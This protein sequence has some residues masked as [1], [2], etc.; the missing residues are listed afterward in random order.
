MAATADA[1][2]PKWFRHLQSMKES[3]AQAMAT[4]TN[5]QAKGLDEAATL[6]KVTT[7]LGRYGTRLAAI[8][9]DDT[10][11]AANV[12]KFQSNIVL[13]GGEDSGDTAHKTELQK[14]A[15]AEY[16]AVVKPLYRKFMMRDAEVWSGITHG[17]V[18]SLGLA[19]KFKVMVPQTKDTTWRTFQTVN[20]YLRVMNDEPLPSA[21]KIIDV[22]MSL[23]SDVSSEEDMANIHKRILETL[24]GGDSSFNMSDLSE[25]T[26]LMGKTNMDDMMAGKAFKNLDKSTRKSLRKNTKKLVNDVINQ[27][28]GDSDS[29][30]D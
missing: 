17:A 8:F 5:A 26:S 28:L 7:I 30:S 21:N 6:A 12:R 4:E 13:Q 16:W 2:A 23:P 25:L 11:L 24:G 19:H 14:M 18:S 20:A 15:M 29:D 10:D 9:K 27:L 1:D 3:Y 22:L